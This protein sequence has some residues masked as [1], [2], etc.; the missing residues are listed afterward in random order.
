MRLLFV[1]LGNICRSPTAEGVFR[2]LA[3]REGLLDRY[4]LDSAGTGDWHVGSDPDPRMV[5]AAVAQGYRLEGKARQVRAEDFSDF[6]LILAMDR[7]NHRDLLKMAPDLARE[8]IQLFRVHDPEEAGSDVPDP[9]YGGPDGF[10]QVV[11]IVERNA[12]IWLERTA[13]GVR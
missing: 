7:N 2:E 10:R 11:Q 6:D 9:Y 1:C 5:D 12:R 3:R 13:G 8:R 4:T